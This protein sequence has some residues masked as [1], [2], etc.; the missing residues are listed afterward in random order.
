MEVAFEAE[1]RAHT[2]PQRPKRSWVGRGVNLHVFIQ[3]WWSWPYCV[4]HSPGHHWASLVAQMVKNL[5]AMQE[6]W[7]WS[8][9][10]ENPLEEGMATHS[11]ILAWR[12][13]WTEDP[14]RLQSMGSRRVRHNWTHTHTYTCIY[15]HV[16]HSWDH[17]GYEFLAFLFHLA[18]HYK[19][20]LACCDHHWYSILPFYNL[21]SHI[22]VVVTD[23]YHTSIGNI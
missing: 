4:F 18:V 19:L 7:V 1:G 3:S 5:T 9:G 12:I 22:P 23:L 17:T 8:L 10:W 6:S 14:G 11:S 13:P 20:L 16:S 21:V 15:V 2:K